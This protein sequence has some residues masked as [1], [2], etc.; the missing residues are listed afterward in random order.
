MTN[1]WST[2][3]NKYMMG[4]KYG[5]HCEYQEEIIVWDWSILLSG[6]GASYNRHQERKQEKKRKNEEYAVHNIN[7]YNNNLLCDKIFC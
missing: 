2:E 3:A 1:L 6:A 5:V 4:P 7:L